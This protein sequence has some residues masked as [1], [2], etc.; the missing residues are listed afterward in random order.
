M[1]EAL[2]EVPVLDFI[3]APSGPTRERNAEPGDGK[4]GLGLPR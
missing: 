3:G 2:D 1:S 4:E